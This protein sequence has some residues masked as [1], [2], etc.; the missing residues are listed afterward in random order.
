MSEPTRGSDQTPLALAC[1]AYQHWLREGA[2]GRLHL[3]EPEGENICSAVEGRG[4]GR[5]RTAWRRLCLTLATHVP[6][7]GWKVFWY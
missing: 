6:N 2:K 3:K 1:Q 7:N 5:L 4:L